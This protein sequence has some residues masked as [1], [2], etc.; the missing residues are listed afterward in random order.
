MGSFLTKDKTCLYIINKKSNIT[1]INTVEEHKKEQML[2]KF[3]KISENLPNG[4]MQYNSI[5]SF[6]DGKMSYAEMRARCG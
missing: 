6:F 3:K 2:N 5:K 1:P 4:E